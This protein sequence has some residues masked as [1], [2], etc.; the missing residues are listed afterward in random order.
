METFQNIFY[1]I[2]LPS[3]ILFIFFYFT[4]QKLRIFNKN[5]VLMIS[6]LL[7]LISAYFLYTYKISIYL[8]LI[9]GTSFV[10]LFSF[11][12]LKKIKESYEKFEKKEGKKQKELDEL[13]IQNLVL[14]IIEAERKDEREKVEEMRE[15]LKEM[16]E[17]FKEK[18]GEEA[19]N[20]L[21]EKYKRFL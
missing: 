11:G 15:V 8:G 4:L 6:F 1:G 19:Y 13:K 21:K 12:F 20:S 17:E 5:S 16:L 10:L 7:S 2:I 14:Q 9:L 3:S 18:Y